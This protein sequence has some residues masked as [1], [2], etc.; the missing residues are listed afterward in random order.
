M[1]TVSKLLVALLRTLT[2]LVVAVTLPLSVNV[3]VV[4]VTPVPPVTE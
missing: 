4:A 2:S 1:L 3:A